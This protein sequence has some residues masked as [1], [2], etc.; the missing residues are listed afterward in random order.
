MRAGLVLIGPLIPIIK[1][2]Y[3]LSNTAL[4]F[5]AGIPL[6]CFA[7][8]S[9]IMRHVVKIG[10]SNLIIRWAITVLAIS[11]IARAF[12]GLMGLYI[13]SF[14]MGIAIAVMNYEIPAWVKEYTPSSAGLITGIYVTIMGA[15]GAIAV[16]VSVPL[17][18]LNSLSWKMAMIPW[19]VI[20]LLS[21]SFW[22]RKIPNQVNLVEQVALNFWRSKAFK[23]PLAWALV[24]FFGLESMSFYATATW[25]PTI[26][27]TKDFTLTQAAVSVSISGL[28]GS[29]VGLAV[30]HYVGKVEDQRLI[31][32]AIS[33]LSGFS[34]FMMTLQSG[35]I[36]FLWLCLSNIGIS[37]AFPVA[38]LLCS[39]KSDSPE[40]TRNLSTMMQSLGYVISASGPFFMGALYESSKNW[41]IALYGI[42]GVIILQLAM[43]MIVGRPSQIE[44]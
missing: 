18:E 9:L 36:I 30:P 20:A 44:Y 11:L 37:I 29:F 3:Q 32:V 14:S 28:V 15:A 39:A 40:A 6:I 7:G 16:A 19:M 8:S 35:A 5:L 43:G 24:F 1:N 22:W 38:L 33:A 41:D 27:T 2:Y 31:L 21:A 25:L 10:S 17:A 4:A 42:V 23:N 34:F 13:F 26:L 12:T